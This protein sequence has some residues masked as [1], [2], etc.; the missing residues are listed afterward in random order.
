MYYLLILCL[1]Y[2]TAVKDVVYIEWP[3]TSITFLGFA[4]PWTYF[5]DNLS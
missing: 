5:K 2:V 4:F 1:I 3:L